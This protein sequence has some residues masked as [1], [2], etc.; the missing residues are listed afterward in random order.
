VT[1]LHTGEHYARKEVPWK[2]MPEWGIFTESA[3]KERLMKEIDLVETA[4]HVCTLSFFPTS[5]ITLFKLTAVPGS[6]CPVF[7]P[8]GL[9]DG[10]DCPN[11]HAGL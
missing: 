8:P 10:S 5:I 6:Y 7:S 1:D 2:E 4:T 3:F 9:G 11:I